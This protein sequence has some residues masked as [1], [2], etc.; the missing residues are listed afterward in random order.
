MRQKIHIG[1][2]VSRI[3][4]LDVEVLLHLVRPAVDHVDVF[5]GREVYATVDRQ[6]ARDRFA[7]NRQDLRTVQAPNARLGPTEHQHAPIGHPHVNPLI[8]VQYL[9][10]NS[11]QRQVHQ[12]FVVDRIA[13]RVDQHPVVVRAH[14]D[15]VRSD[16]VS[17]D[18]TALLH[19]L[20]TGHDGLV[21]TEAGHLAESSVALMLG[22]VVSQDRHVTV[23]LV[24]RAYPQRVGV[25]RALPSRR[26]QT[27]RPRRCQVR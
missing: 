18:Q 3:R 24:R 2:H 19:V 15:R 9:T 7:L 10:R 20:H 17:G 21:Q 1:T 6:Q 8:K 4:V 16:V 5:A 13:G 25:L 22:T 11:R 27:I 12:L 14:P 26:F 23:D